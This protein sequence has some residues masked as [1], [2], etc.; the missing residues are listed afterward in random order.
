MRKRGTISRTTYYRRQR[1]ARALNCSVNEL[2]DGRGCHGNHASGHRNNRW[3]EAGVT[4][5]RTG[6]V[7]VRVGKNHPLAFGGGYCYL[8]N[9]I[10]T[11]SKHTKLHDNNRKRKNGRYL[12]IQ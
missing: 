11:N 4:I 8:H 2:P 6:Y 10:M 9:L 1:E 3:N 5:T 7:L 12:K